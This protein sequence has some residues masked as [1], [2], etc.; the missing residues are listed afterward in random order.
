[1]PVWGGAKIFLAQSRIKIDSDVWLDFG[2]WIMLKTFQH[3]LWTSSPVFYL[4]LLYNSTGK[5]KKLS[6]RFKLET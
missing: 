4:K 1:M 2:K 3:P 5:K 6:V